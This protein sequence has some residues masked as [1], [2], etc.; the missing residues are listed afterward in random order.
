VNENPPI[1]LPK[2]DPAAAAAAVFG[3]PDTNPTGASP[4][5]ASA[6]MVDEVIA[7]SRDRQSNG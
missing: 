7:T 1:L 2:L 3:A 4:T 6:P 5:G